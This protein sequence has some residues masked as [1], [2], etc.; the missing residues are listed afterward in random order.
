ML[1]KENYKRL[2]AQAFREVDRKL[3]I[4]AY[5]ISARTQRMDAVLDLI[6][7]AIGRTTLS[8]YNGTIYWF[9]GKY[10]EPV[11]KDDF[12]NFV[13]D[14]LRALKVPYGDYGR[15]EGMTKVLRRKVLSKQLRATAN[16]MSFN[17]GVLDMTTGKL[18]K[19]T[20][21]IVTFSCADYDYNPKAKGYRWQAFLDEVLPENTYQRILQEFVGAMFVDRRVAK[22]EKMLI[23]KGSGSN[24]KSVVFETIIALLGKENVS[25]FALDELIGST[26]STERKRNIAKINGKRL[27]YASEMSKM[28]IEGG[29]GQLKALISGEPLEGRAMYGENFTAYD[30]PLIMINTNHMPSIKDWSYGMR[31]RISVLPFDIEI[32][33]WKQDPTLPATLRSELPAIFN[34]AMEGRNRFIENNYHFTENK[35]LEGM[36]DQYH[37]ESSTMLQFMIRKGYE[38]ESTV[39][40]DAVPIWVPFKDLYDEYAKWCVT[41]DEVRESKKAAGTTLK[42]AGY[43]RSENKEGIFYAI[44][45]EAAMRRATREL[46]LDLAY[47]E[48]NLARR[49]MLH[50]DMRKLTDTANRI[51]DERGWKRCCV[52][53]LELSEY[54]GYNVNW[55]FRMKTLEGMYVVEDG[56]FY[57]NLDA[58][59]TQWRPKYEA[60]IKERYQNSIADKAFNEMMEQTKVEN[61]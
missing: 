32:P 22:I 15:I 45:G 52:G 19:P 11:D 31:R 54:V 51:M 56:R 17:N 7:S 26:G 13:Y 16:A 1:S 61:Q 10:Y 23:L 39:L 24:G 27:N 40:K 14:L 58:I 29:S 43:K 18:K 53:F 28:N 46:H 3:L 44:F 5:N 59:D 49:S 33:K 30:I 4:D 34:W 55:K 25:N 38:R 2:V 48:Y 36:I 37:A 6:R 42:D 41:Y 47:K 35:V 12:G 60:R 20:K 9:N 57:F 50:Y 21:K 8:Q